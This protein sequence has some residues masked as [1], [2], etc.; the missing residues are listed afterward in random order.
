MTFHPLY[1]ELA[2]QPDFAEP[3]AAFV[4]VLPQ[5]ATAMEDALEEGE[6]QA[7][8]VLAH[9]LKGAAGCYGFPSITAA[10]GGVERSLE[11]PTTRHALREKMAV[12][13][14]LCRRA[15]APAE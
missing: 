14:E 12:L 2:G 11:A 10:V 5:R 6:L 7:L 13:A 9:Q 15:R 3:L 8:G 1:S 4:A